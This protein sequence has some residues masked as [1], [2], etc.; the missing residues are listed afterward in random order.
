LTVFVDTSGLYALL[1]EEDQAH[2]RSLRIAQA[3][4]DANEVLVTHS[5]VVSESVALVHRRMGWPG[6]DVLLADAL[7]RI[8]TRWVDRE[9]HERALGAM[10][11]A[12]SSVSF[13]DWVSFALMR[14]EGIETAFAFDDD[15]ERQGFRLLG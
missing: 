2:A 6:L 14:R 9:L 3:L 1:V 7:P 13:V 5:Y 12:R 15:F 4:R 11:A 8:E 10:R